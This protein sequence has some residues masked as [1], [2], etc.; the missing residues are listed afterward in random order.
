[1]VACPS[2]K[3]LTSHDSSNPAMPPMTHDEQ[4]GIVTEC[5]HNKRYFLRQLFQSMPAVL[6][7]FSQSTADVFIAEMAGNFT[8][9]DPKIG[10]KIG[11]LLNREVRLRYNPGATG[12]AIEARVIFSPHITGTPALFA[13]NRKKVL[14]QLVAEA[15]VG[16][17]NLNP[18]TGHLARPFGNCTLCPTMAIGPCDYAAELKPVGQL[19]SAV[20]EA[21]AAPSQSEKAQN[22]AMLESF[23]AH[24]RQRTQASPQVASADAGLQKN[25]ATDRTVDAWAL[26]G[27]PDRDVT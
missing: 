25:S 6:M 13:A 26:A 16:G 5:F 14:A 18:A 22:M 15:Q 23:L 24:G 12:S 3:W 21:D 27:R 8:K 9:G 10:D 7:V 17:L 20:A 19:V 1:M 2:A 4:R 11:D